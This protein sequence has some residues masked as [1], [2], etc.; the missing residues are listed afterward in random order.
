MTPEEQIKEL[1]EQNAELEAILQQSYQAKIIELA[2]I[3]GERERSI[4]EK[5]Y[6]MTENIQIYRLSKYIILDILLTYHRIK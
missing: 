2:D 4:L 5:I 1:Q 6:Y 3:T